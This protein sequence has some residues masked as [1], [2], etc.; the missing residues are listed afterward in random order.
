MP[1]RRQP[2]T[3]LEPL[4]YLDV[5]ESFVAA[6]WPRRAGGRRVEK[7]RAPART[8]VF[9]LLVSFFFIFPVRA[10]SLIADLSNPLVAITTGF[11]GA[12]VLLFGAV[13]GPGDLVVTVMGPEETAKVYRKTQ[14]AGIWM[15]TASMT[16]TQVPSFYSISS[17]RKLADITGPRVLKS[18]QMG[19]EYLRLDL[20]SAIVS[21]NLAREW[22]QGLIR[23]K[24]QSGLYAIQP[25][26]VAFVGDKLFR[27]TLYLPPNVPVGRYQVV[28]YLLRDGKM[29]SAQTSPLFISKIG[30]E[31]D[32]HT[33]AQRY[34]ALYG[35]VAIALALFAGWLGHV[36]FHR[37]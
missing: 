4:S 34:S 12:E 19:L 24:E 9:T 18:H 37:S 30:L 6:P 33:F 21:A 2:P 28:T 20:P 17:S 35:L 31:A 13:D 10:I 8:L 11:A 36:I 27:T 7:R 5:G 16:F 26:R 29:V 25:D 23:N 3:R 15:N 32:I 22:R 1:R 14:V